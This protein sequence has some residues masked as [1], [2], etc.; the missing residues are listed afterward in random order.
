M[1]NLLHRCQPWIA[2]NSKL[3][4]LVKFVADTALFGG[5]LL[6]PSALPAELTDAFLKPLRSRLFHS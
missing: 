6:R 2:L 3:V 1:R 5:A 4:K